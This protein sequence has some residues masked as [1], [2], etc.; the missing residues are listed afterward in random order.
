MMQYL[1]EVLSDGV[2]TLKEITNFDAE[3]LH[4]MLSDKYLCDKAGLIVHTHINQTLDFIYEGNYAAN[5]GYQ[6]FYGIFN[7]EDV[8]VGLI[9]LFNI[10][11]TNNTGEYGYFI[12]SKHTRKSY[13]TRSIK[14]LSNYLLEKTKLESINVYVDTSNSASLA[15]AKNLNLKEYNRGVEEDQSSRSIEMIQFVIKEKF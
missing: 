12:S 8:L 2:V 14:L 15:L 9:N 7:E 4:E 1:Q 3:A 13:M 5:S 10:D 6:Y 11:F